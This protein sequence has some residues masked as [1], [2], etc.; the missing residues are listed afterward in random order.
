MMS[1][2]FTNYLFILLVH[3]TGPMLID[4]VEKSPK[5]DDTKTAL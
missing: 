5:N 1:C 3:S 2:P 4:N